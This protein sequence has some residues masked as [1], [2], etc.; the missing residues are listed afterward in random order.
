MVVYLYRC[1]EHGP[2]ETACPMGSAPRS[3]ACPTCGG[4]TARVYTA[5]RLSLGSPV[6]R[7]LIERAQRSAAEPDV[8]A[9]PPPRPQR[10]QAPADP[11]HTRLPRL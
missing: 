1:P 5:P 10:R 7:A 2:L 3:P 6:R 8:V 11:R 9:A 4:Q